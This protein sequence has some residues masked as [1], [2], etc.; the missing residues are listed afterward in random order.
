MGNDNGFGE[1]LLLWCNA[2]DPRFDA[3]L[4]RGTHRK[5]AP[6]GAK[7]IL[8]SRCLSDDVARS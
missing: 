5:G 3:R 7:H 4:P 8:L 2:A 1:A 6:R